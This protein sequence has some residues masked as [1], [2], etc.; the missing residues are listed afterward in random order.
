MPSKLVMVSWE[1]YINHLAEVAELVAEASG[2]GDANLVAAAL[3][4]DT[5]EDTETTPEEL[6]ATFNADV[7]AL[8]VEATDDMSLP[9]AVRKAKQVESAPH[10]SARA[11]LLKL[12]D[13]TS[14]PQALAVSPPANWDRA[15]RLAYVDWALEVAA[16]LRGE[17]PWLEERFDEAV[18][19]AR[20]LL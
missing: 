17:N 15:R 9:Q 19:E 7:A 18:A 5:V 11:K 4:H 13:K 8:V 16:G 12:A 6:A 2:G 1:P 3:L 14:N 20:R 10:K